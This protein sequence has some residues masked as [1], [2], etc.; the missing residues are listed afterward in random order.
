MGNSRKTSL[1]V[2]AA[3]DAGPC[4]I[5]IT[6]NL[7]RRRAAVQTGCAEPLIIWSAW[8]TPDDEARN[9]EMLVHRQFAEQ[10]L[11]GEWFAITV[12]EAEDFIGRIDEEEDGFRWLCTHKWDFPAR[13]YINRTACLIERRDQK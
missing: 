1:Y 6:G 12:K 7:K 13:L 11:K 8:S 5:G 2:M 3:S 9:T 10:R 4:K